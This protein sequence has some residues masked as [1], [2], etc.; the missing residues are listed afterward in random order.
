M[1]SYPELHW[2]IFSDEHLYKVLNLAKGLYGAD[3]KISFI[4]ATRSSLGE[5]G[6][7]YSR[8]AARF[9][10]LMILEK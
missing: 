5:D 4:S 8:A 2:S 6:L 7:I 10:H 1:T 9:Q 3:I